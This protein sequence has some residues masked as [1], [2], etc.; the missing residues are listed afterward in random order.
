MTPRPTTG[1]GSDT[2]N[3]HIP[4]EN[5]ASARRLSEVSGSVGKA[6]DTSNAHSVWESARL[7]EVSGGSGRLGGEPDPFNVDIDP[8]C[9][10]S[11][12]A[13]LDRDGMRLTRCGSRWFDWQASSPRLAACGIASRAAEDY[14][15]ALVVGLGNRPPL[16]FVI[17][18]SLRVL[19]SLIHI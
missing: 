9:T 19:L 16:T 12:V 15:R 18:A 13:A 5:R 11:I 10:A 8:T 2:S 14:V 7:S 3:A 4:R 17:H 6:S 1:T